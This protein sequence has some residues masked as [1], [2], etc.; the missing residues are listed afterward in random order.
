MAAVAGGNLLAGLAQGG[1]RLL[2]DMA[3]EALDATGAY[4]A[5]AMSMQS[6]AGREMLNAG[7]AENM[8]EAYDLAAGRATELLDWTQQLAILSPFD[9]GGVAQ[10]FRT[11]MAYGFASEEAQ[12]LTQATIDFATATGQ[13][14]SEMN[15]IALALGQMASR[16]KVSMQEILQLTNAGVPAMQMLA[17]AFNMAGGDLEDAFR[18]GSITAEQAIEALTAGLEHDFGGAAAR[19][20]ESVNGLLNSLSD[21]KEMGLRK[22]FGGMFEALQPV[23]AGFAE[24]LQ[25]DG[26][27]KLEA[28]GAKIGDVTQS[29]LFMGKG[30]VGTLNGEDVNHFFAVAASNFPQFREQIFGLQDGLQAFQGAIADGATPVEAFGS[31]LTAIGVDSGIVDTILG[32]GESFGGLLESFG[33]LGESIKGTFPEMLASGQTFGA[34]FTGSFMPLVLN[35]IDTLS[36]GISTLA[37]LWAQWGPTIIPVVTA[38][39]QM[40]LS[41]VTGV[42]GLI[43]SVVTAGLQLLQGNWTGALNTISGFLSSFA[44]NVTA[45][46]GTTWQN[47]VATWSTN[48]QTLGLIISTA[49]QNLVTTIFNAANQLVAFLKSTFTSLITYTITAFLQLINAIVTS[50]NEALATVQG[51]AAAFVDAGRNLMQGLINGAE[52]LAGAFIDKLTNIA[53]NAVDAVA[54]VFQTGSPSRVTYQLSQYAMQGLM[55]GPEKMGGA[56]VGSFGQVASQIVDALQMPAAKPAG[57]DFAPVDAAA[58]GGG[59]MNITIIVDGGLTPDQY[60]AQLFT[61]LEEFARGKG[62]TILSKRTRRQS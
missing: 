40:V 57:L 55:L 9:Q 56:V 30:I 23:V 47:V 50:A 12:R 60:I 15:S 2:G 33:T 58:G 32:L 19:A 4:E 13:G 38:A 1:V 28:W 5:M 14:T 45:I 22:L 46:F 17:D 34:W 6:L 54:N 42:I 29:L 18:D 51:F 20:G 26:L 41:V 49:W 31:A 61:K 53:R 24:W 52:S 48:F 3:R 21:I 39:F 44:N 25:G 7:E 11:A 43:V 37:A 27:A 59:N 8:A 36:T 35:V 62:F 10:A 16:G